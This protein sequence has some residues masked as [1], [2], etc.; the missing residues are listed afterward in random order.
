VNKRDF[1]NALASLDKVIA[2]FQARL[3]ALKKLNTDLD[4]MLATAE[5]AAAPASPSTEDSPTPSP[6]SSPT[7]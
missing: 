5:L 7:T 6:A 1:N 4:E 3:D 2:K